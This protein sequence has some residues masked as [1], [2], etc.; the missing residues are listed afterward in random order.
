MFDWIFLAPQLHAFRLLINSVYGSLLRARMEQFRSEEMAPGRLE[1][2]GEGET[3]GK[4][5]CYSTGSFWA[6]D[7]H[8]V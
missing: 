5:F 8:G 3:S 4:S 2:E 6:G 1:R 7:I